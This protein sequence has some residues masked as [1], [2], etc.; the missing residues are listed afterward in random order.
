MRCTAHTWHSRNHGHLREDC[1]REVGLATTDERVFDSG[2]GFLKI[3]K[4]RLWMWH[5]LEEI[6]HKGVAFDVYEAVGGGYLRRALAM[7]WVT[8]L[9]A[10]TLGVIR[11]YLH[12]S[13]PCV[14]AR[15]YM[16]SQRVP[17]SRS[18]LCLLGMA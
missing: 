11:I 1:R 3:A 14:R 4:S 12:W 15:K 5:A 18:R 2:V 16:Q 9:F 8:V 17:W 7:L 13:V 6:E 10:L